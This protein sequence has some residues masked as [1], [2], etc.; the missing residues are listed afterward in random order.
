MARVSFSA[1]IE[2][3]VG[4]LGGS[5]FQ[6]SYGGMQIRTRVSPRNPQTTFQQ[7]RRGEFGYITQG[8][9]NLTSVERQTFID[10]ATTPPAALNLFVQSNVNLSLINE[11]TITSYVTTAVPDPFTMVIDEATPT[12]LIVR[13]TGGLTTVPADTKLL[14]YATQLR[15]PTQIF[16]N[17]SMYSPIISF[18]EGTD[19]ATPVD[20]LA[21]WQ[22]R[23]GQLLDE[24]RLCIKCCLINKLNGSRGAE[25]FDCTNTEAMPAKYIPLA[26]FVTS[27]PTSGTGNE[28][29]YT[30]SM[31]ANTLL[32]A[33]DRLHFVG[34]FASTG[35]A[36][37][38]YMDIRFNGV[39]FFTPVSFAN[40]TYGFEG[41]IVLIDATHVKVS[42][43][44][45][46]GAAAAK[47][48]QGTNFTIDPT[49]S[50][51]IVFRANSDIA[52]DITAQYLCIDLIKAA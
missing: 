29:L 37:S 50:N 4:K 5:V 32:T 48:G 1:L 25:A 26:N 12:T 20:V 30:Y 15:F 7:L 10:A 46:D 52:G 19:L 42:G 36:G 45:G 6:D 31:P 34:R 13:A 43:W 23:Y 8:W 41:E 47:W 3:I 17:P 49:V 11:A 2:E 28:D 44:F 39:T 33:G 9:R 40:D 16:T 27:T 18:D 35:A 24:K 21:E 14:L 51:N 38:K 22:V